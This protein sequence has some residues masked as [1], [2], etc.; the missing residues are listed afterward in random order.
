MPARRSRAAWPLRPRRAAAPNRRRAV[1]VGLRRAATRSL[2]PGPPA[3]ATQ[4]C[5][6]RG[7]VLS[8]LSALA[9]YPWLGARQPCPEANAGEMPAHR[10]ETGGAG[11]RRRA[12]V[13]ARLHLLCPQRL[14]G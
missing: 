8:D 4:A 13:T 10:T 6:R 12:W 3:L 5:L 7:G 1:A 14:R 2:V 9:R 11:W